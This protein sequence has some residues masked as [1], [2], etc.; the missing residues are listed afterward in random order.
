MI[1]L[2]EVTVSYPFILNVYEDFETEVI[3][4]NDFIEILQTVQSFVFRRFIARLGTAALNKIFT[5]LY[6]EIDKNDYI[7]S[8]K[9]KL[10]RKQR[11]QRFPND[12]EIN[13]E[14]KYKDLYNINSQKRKYLFLQLE[15]YFHKE[16]ISFEDYSIEHI[17]PQEPHL[18]WKSELLPDE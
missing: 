12:N 8:L 17:F 6:Y 14:L 9:F 10:V 3:S 13:N 15:N 4:K 11:S 1:N 18:K 5:T 2:L 16:P 7:D